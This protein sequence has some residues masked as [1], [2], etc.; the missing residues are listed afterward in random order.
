MKEIKWS[1]GERAVRADLPEEVLFQRGRKT[2]RE[3]V[4]AKGTVC[5][6]LRPERAQGIES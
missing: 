6:A 5:G 4:Q 1:L 3:S 2:E